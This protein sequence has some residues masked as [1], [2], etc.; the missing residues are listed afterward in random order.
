MSFSNEKLRCLEK[1]LIIDLSRAI[2]SI[3]RIKDEISLSHCG[4]FSW[5]N[6]TKTNFEK[7]DELI[8]NLLVD[9]NL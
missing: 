2:F 3:E 6:M 4:S 7:L 9:I 5:L 8:S 1:E